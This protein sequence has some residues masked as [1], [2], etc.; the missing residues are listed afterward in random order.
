VWVIAR[1]RLVFGPSC[2]RPQRVVAVFSGDE[3]DRGAP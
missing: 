3:E 1:R 2:S